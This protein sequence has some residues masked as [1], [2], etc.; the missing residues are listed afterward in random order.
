MYNI[1]M[2]T[3]VGL[4]NAEYAVHCMFQRRGATSSISGVDVSWTSGWNY[5]PVSPVAT[6]IITIIAALG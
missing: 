5:T 1:A 3:K 6:A 2:T 4:N